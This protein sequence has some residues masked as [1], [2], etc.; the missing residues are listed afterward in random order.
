MYNLNIKRHF[1]VVQYV[2]MLAQGID[3]IEVNA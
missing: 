3:T 2:V 1:A